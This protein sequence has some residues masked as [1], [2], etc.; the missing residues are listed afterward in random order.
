M[1]VL[2]TLRVALSKRLFRW[3][4]SVLSIGPMRFQVGQGFFQTG[5]RIVINPNGDPAI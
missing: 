3:N 2:T 4:Q 1:E 5:T